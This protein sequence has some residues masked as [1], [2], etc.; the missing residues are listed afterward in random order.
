MNRD[1]SKKRKRK[2]PQNQ[3]SQSRNGAAPVKGRT[4]PVR[5]NVYPLQPRESYRGTEPYARRPAQ[6]PSGGAVKKEKKRRRRVNRVLPMFVFVIIAIYLCG[7]MATM[8]VKNSDI[9]VE[10]VAYGSIATPQ[11]YTA[12]I[13][14]TEYVVKS[15]RSGQVFYNYAEGDYISKNAAVCAVKDVSSTDAIETR[16]E[17]IDKDILKSQKSRTDLSA[18]SEDIARIESNIQRTVDSVAGKSMAADMSFAYDLKNQVQLFMNQRNEIWLT[19]NVESLSQ[20]T[21]EKNRYQQ[22]LAQNMSTIRSRES[23]ILSLSYDGL[24]ET[25]TPQGLDDLTQAQIGDGRMTYISKAKAVAEGDPLF[26]IIAS[27]QWYMVAY[28]PNSAAAGW[29]RGGSQTLDLQHEDGVIPISAKIES[30]EIG[31]TETRVVFST[32]EQMESFMNQRNLEFRIESTTTQGLKVPNDAIVEKSLIAIPRDCLTESNGNNG[33]LLVNGE[34]ARFLAVN[35]ITSDEENYYVDQSGTLKLGDVILQGTG[36]N[37]TQY[38]VA[39]LK[40]R[41]G[42][43]VANSSLARFVTID[44]L[45]QNQEYAI[46]RSGTTYGLQAY[47]TI[48]SDAKNISEGESIY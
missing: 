15:D 8:A 29:T 12:L 3:Q 45:E 41:T 10:T 13:V 31:E 23:G 24:E 25:L 33:V 47:D 5:D 18:F 34:N 19:E 44:I 6:Q 16:L 2:R 39:A 11:K 7:Q 35:I 30:I 17:T 4:Y 32:Y 1:S 9:N 37:A 14:R 40:P 21:E 27:N 22:Q 20:L 28:L 26:K 38:T 36:E 48:V 43:Y 42:V 46:I